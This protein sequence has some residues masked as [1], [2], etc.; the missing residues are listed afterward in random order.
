MPKAIYICQ[1]KVIDCK[2]EVPEDPTSAV[3]GGSLVLQGAF[4]PVNLVNEDE[5]KVAY[6]QSTGAQTLPISRLAEPGPKL[7]QSILLLQIVH[8]YGIWTRSIYGPRD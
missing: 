1:I 5:I 7:G 4:V 8:P 6:V 2:R 3:I